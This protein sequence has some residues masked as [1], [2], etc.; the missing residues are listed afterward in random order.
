MDPRRGAPATEPY[1]IEE[2]STFLREGKPGMFKL[3]NFKANDQRFPCVL[4]LFPVKGPPAANPTAMDS[5]AA[6]DGEYLY[7]IGVVIDV[8][9]PHAEV[10]PS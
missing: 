7:Q 9:R 10:R 8:V 5:D 4:N 6:R 1:M 3:T 2:V